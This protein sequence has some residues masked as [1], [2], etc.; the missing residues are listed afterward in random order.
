MK[1]KNQ[2]YNLSGGFLNFT[3]RLMHKVANPVPANREIFLIPGPVEN[4]GFSFYGF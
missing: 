3:L 4:K 1:Q 2:F